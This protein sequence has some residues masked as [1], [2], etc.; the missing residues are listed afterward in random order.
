MIYRILGFFIIISYLFSTNIYSCTTFFLKDKLGNYYFGRNFDFPTGL[1]TININQRNVLKI[2]FAIKGE[3]PFEWTSKYGSVTFNQNGREFPYGGINEAGLVIEQ[4]WM[5]ETVYP[6]I[7]DR[8]GLEELQWI[9]YQLDVSSTVEEVI[10]SD[11]KVRVSNNSLA[12]LHFSVADEN[13]NFAVVEYI[14]GMMVYYNGKDAQIYV[15]ANENYKS[16]LAKTKANDKSQRFVKA[17]NLLEAYQETQKNGLDYAFEIL[18]NLSQGE[19]TRWSIVYD[20]KHLVIYY[21]TGTN[22]NIRKINLRD[23]NFNCSPK[24]LFIGIDEGENGIVHFKDFN[25][26]DN[27]SLIDKVWNGIEFLKVLSIKF[28][29]AWARYPESVI[30]V[31]SN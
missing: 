28:K 6:K 19:W 15:L 2:S 8:A 5:D 30:C 9:Q 11:A 10:R 27:Y 21:K 3:Q 25:Y 23:F 4:L 12:T 26:E 14:N 1:G 16:G 20:V 24:K 13:G 31:T 17:A 29:E 7:D 18:K 22:E